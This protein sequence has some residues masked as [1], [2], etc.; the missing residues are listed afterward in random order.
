MN[1]YFRFSGIQS[2]L[3]LIHFRRQGLL[4]SSM[5]AAVIIGKRE[6]P[7]DEGGN[8]EVPESFFV[9]ECITGTAGSG[10]RIVVAQQK[11]YNG[12]YGGS[13]NGQE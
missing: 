8:Q 6:D 11:Y 2:L 9:S 12:L 3:L 4:V 1:I 10:V 13:F 7:S 5:A